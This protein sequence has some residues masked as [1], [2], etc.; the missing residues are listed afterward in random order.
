MNAHR[1][2]ELLRA[3]GQKDDHTDTR[4]LADV[5]ATNVRFASQFA[6]GGVLRHRASY[7]C[8]DF[9]TLCDAICHYLWREGLPHPR[10]AA[11]GIATPIVGDHV[12]M[13]NHRWSFSIQAVQ[14]ALGLERLLVMNDFSALALSLPA[15]DAADLRKIG[16]GEAVVGAPMGLIGPCTGLGV[17]GLVPAMQGGALVPLSG[18]GGHVSLCAMAPQEQEV[19]QVLQ[20]RFGHVSAER[21]L[22]RPGLENLYQALAELRGLNVPARDAASISQAAL[23]GGDPLSEDTLQM[24][25]GLLG[26][27]AGNI[28][29]TL[30]ARGGL[31]IGGSIV[32]RLGDW[33]ARSVFRPRFEAKGRFS[34]YLQDIP[35]YVLRTGDESALLG[36]SRA[37]D[38]GLAAC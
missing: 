22:S 18:E 1:D 14:H 17:S 2:P 31:Y 3:A 34:R 19:L 25:C 38:A 29:L 6:P 10:S 27:M 32:P 33:F 20:R 16:G 21:A 30:G 13:T 37:L 15:L 11:I 24:F 5:G 28:A 8:S 35:T 23:A 9:E 4:L 12:R 26:D 36:A 7:A